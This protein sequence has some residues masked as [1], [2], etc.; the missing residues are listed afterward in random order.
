MREPRL[1]PPAPTYSR[2]KLAALITAYIA[3]AEYVDPRPFHSTGLARFLYV[4]LVLEVARQLIVGRL[5]TD[6]A[7]VKRGAT[8]REWWDGIRARL[9]ADARW[10]FR[11]SITIAGAIYLFGWLLDQLTTRC[12]GALQCAL[13]APRLA[14]ENLPQA[15]QIALYIAIGLLQLFAMF[16][17]M[18]KVGF[19]KIVMPGTID[20]TFDDVY[21]QDGARDKVRE[22]VQL[23]EDDEAVARAGGYM[24][25]GILLYGPPGTGK[26]ML[27][28]AA[29][30]YSTKPLILVPPGGFASTFVGINFLKV[31]SLF[32]MVR[33]LARRHGGVIV[34][35]DEIDSLGNRG[36]GV[37]EA[38]P[39]TFDGCIPFQM[40]PAPIIVGGGNGMNMGTLEA[41]LS[42]MDGMDEPRGLINRLLVFLGFKPLPAPPY[43]YLMMGATNR[44]AALDPALLRAGRFGRKIHVPR[45]KLEGRLKTYQGYL[46]K[47]SHSLTDDQTEWAARNHADGTGAEIKDIVNE[48]LLV[49][50]RDERETQGVVEFDDLMKAMLWVKFG[51]SDGQFERE[52]NRW[53]VAV[54]EAGHAVA[55]HHLAK[56]DLRI[57]F[58]TVEQHGRTGGMV[59]P[60]SLTDD[61]IFGRSKLLAQIQI[62]LAS[63]VAETL[64]LG[65]ATNGHAGDGQAATA[66]AEQMV[67]NGLVKGQ[68][69]IYSEDHDSWR[70]LVENVLAEA[71]NLT[72]Q[73]LD[74]KRDQIEAVARLL[75]EKGTVPGDEIHSLI[76]SMEAA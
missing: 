6:M 38:R 16:Y 7:A 19:V 56:D 37:E 28:K 68:I 34:F 2:L 13:L 18:T 33:K 35:I 42:A 8:I 14:L 24:P 41:F 32:R 50:F 45:P 76:D 70:I 5:E 71:L 17:A 23:L 10:R 43:K 52:E 31:W 39:L 75:V 20:V 26:T 69:G 12:E 66:R 9:T 74:R 63:R 22:Q 65:E 21:G 48:A 54:H 73:L 67:R 29:A 60:T 1:R 30:A 46:G 59:A 58:T 47:V 62:S 15:L 64:I 4:A 53:A 57:W 3:L 61:W 49:T 55:F 11:R 40:E 44:L 51:E 25:K 72:D 36:E 27:A